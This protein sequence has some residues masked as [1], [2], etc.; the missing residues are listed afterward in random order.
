MSLA[1]GTYF[2]SIDQRVSN[3]LR[4]RGW[5]PSQLGSPASPS[6]GAD[7]QQTMLLY[8]R[9]G[10]LDP[11][12]KQCGRCGEH[13]GWS[14]K[15]HVLLPAPPCASCVTLGKSLHPSPPPGPY[16]VVMR[17]MP[18]NVFSKLFMVYKLSLF[19]KLYLSSSTPFLCHAALAYL[20]GQADWEESRG[21]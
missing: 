10:R 4:L 15:V 21:P 1:L 18:G 8:V 7:A 19:L 17:I 9:V 5:H 3:V 20:A 14:Q 11:S 12:G 6:A 16:R 2:P 13:W